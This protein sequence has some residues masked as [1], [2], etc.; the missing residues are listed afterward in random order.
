MGIFDFDQGT[1][2]IDALLV[3]SRLLRRFPLTGGGALRARWTSPRSFALAV[4]G[5]HHGFTPPA[6]FPTLDRLALSLTTGDNPRLT[7]EAYFAL[8]SNTVQFGAHANLYAAAFGFNVQGEAGYDVLIQLMPF[9]FLAEFYAGMQLRKGSRNLFKVKVEGALEGPLPLAVRAKCTFE[10]LWWDVSIRVNVTLV[11]GQA[12]PLPAAVDAFAQL[13]AALAD[14]RSWSAELPPGQTGIVTLR[15]APADG[16]LRAHPLGT[17]A[18]RQGVVPLNL[19][20]DIDKL[21]DAPVAGARRFTVTRVAIGSG[22]D[23]SRA[24]RCWTT[25]RPPSSS[26]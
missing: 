2:A 4:G 20:R 25:S 12:P 1:V 22:S 15:E 9:H 13:R 7:C 23:A 16:V 26:R 6:G 3:D 18:V 24:A 11:G 8:T 21:G 19:E 5:M 17:L 10:I 14:T